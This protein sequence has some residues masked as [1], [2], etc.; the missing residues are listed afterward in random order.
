MLKH[1]SIDS[2][3]MTAAACP[4]LALEVRDCPAQ[5]MLRLLL[6]HCRKLSLM[7][8]KHSESDEQLA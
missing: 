2:N 3:Q 5:A 4:M 7:H 6:W 8:D 1:A